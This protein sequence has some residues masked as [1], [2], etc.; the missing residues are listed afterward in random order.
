MV[1]LAEDGYVV[2]ETLEHLL[3]TLVEDKE[4]VPFRLLTDLGSDTGQLRRAVEASLPASMFD[5]VHEEYMKSNPGVHQ[6]AIYRD[7]SAHL[8]IAIRE[9][10]IEADLCGA[11]EVEPEH[12]LLGILATDESLSARAIRSQGV[13]ADDL[14]SLVATEPDSG[15][16]DRSQYD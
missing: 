3:L 5:Q 14:R 12:L 7:R 13:S 11:A 9:A 2:H 15:P 16:E 8:E 1:T 4:G 10:A 6:A